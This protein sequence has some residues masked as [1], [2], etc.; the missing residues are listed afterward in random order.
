MGGDQV[1]VLDDGLVR[2]LVV[3]IGDL[4]DDECAAAAAELGD[5][6]IG[7]ALDVRDAG[8][9]EAFLCEA[10]ERLGPLDVLVNNAGVA[11]IGMFADE[12]PRDTQR[13]LDINI[14][15]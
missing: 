3:A 2:E 5:R 8:S 4:N 6:A 9:F 11:P 10:E 7:L 1:E 14:V 12:D 13:V 15:D